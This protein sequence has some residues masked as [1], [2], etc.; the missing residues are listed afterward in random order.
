MWEIRIRK[1]S[2]LQISD[3]L[4]SIATKGLAVHEGTPHDEEIESHYHIF[5]ELTDKSES[6]IRKCIQ[7]L[8]KDRKGNELYSM[9]MSHENTPNYCLKEVFKQSSK[10]K[11]WLEND[12]I[13]VIN[14]EWFKSSVSQFYKQFLD[15]V[16]L[17]T[18][19]QSIRKKQKK[20]STFSMIHEIADKYKDETC[21]SPNDFIDDIIKHHTEKDMM[22]PARNLM[23]RYCITIYNLVTNNTNVLRSYYW[24]NF[25]N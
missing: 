3:L 2:D 24:I 15:Y 18:T 6:Y 10:Y 23:E 4:K 20:N 14:D 9:K 8:D 25:H 7:K 11:E 13:H 22:L 17:I 19:K 5:V 16:E 21:N 1:V 12:R